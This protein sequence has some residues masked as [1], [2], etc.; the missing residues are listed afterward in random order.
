LYDLY[1]PGKINYA[2]FG[3]LAPHVHVH[4]VPKYEGTEQWGKPF[5]EEPKKFLS[6]SEYQELIDEIKNRFSELTENHN[7]K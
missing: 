5:P 1:R 7:S 4:V 3:D 2:T 6:D